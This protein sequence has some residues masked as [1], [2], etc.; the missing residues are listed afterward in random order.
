MICFSS[1]LLIMYVCIS[2]RKRRKV[3]GVSDSVERGSSLF[4]LSS[5]SPLSLRTLLIGSER[6]IFLSSISLRHGSSMQK[7]QIR[8]E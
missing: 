7:A 1:S 2:R 6:R 3:I 5:L 8:F 4:S